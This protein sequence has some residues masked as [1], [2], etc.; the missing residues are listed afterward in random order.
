MLWDAVWVED[1]EQPDVR[2]L[3]SK[4]VGPPR[5]HEEDVSGGGEEGFEL[6]KTPLVDDEPLTSSYLYHDGAVKSHTFVIE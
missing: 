3:V 5:G 6:L 1:P 2:C 4:G